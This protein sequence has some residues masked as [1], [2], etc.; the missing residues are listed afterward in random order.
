MEFQ[1][2]N[3]VGGVSDG[4]QNLGNGTGTV[5]PVPFSHKSNCIG[6]H[7]LR[8]SFKKKHLAHIAKFVSHIWGSFDQDGFGLWSYDSRLSW[9]S[10]VSLNYDEDE[11]RSGRVHAGLITLDCPGSALDEVTAPDLQLFIEFCE[12]FGGKCTRIDIFFDDYNRIVTPR[13]VFE[14]AQKGDYSGFRCWSRRERGDRKSCLHDEIAF[15]RRGSYGNGAYLRFYDKNLES[16][17]ESNCC[18]WEVEFTQKKADAVFKK[19]AACGGDID[20]FVT[21]CGSLIAGCVTFIHRTG[22]KNISR[23]ER[24]AWWSAILEIL[25]GVVRVRIERKKD[26]VTGKMQWIERNVAPS[27]ACLKRVFVSD[28]SFF[29]WLFDTLHDG[30]SRMNPFTQQIAR[31][32]ECSINYRWGEFSDHKEQI[33]DKSMSQL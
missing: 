31:E 17:G 24:Y 8:I 23:L 7:W 32:N 30:E 28:K 13:E 6:V 16:D 29:R 3:V 19:L 15:G 27:L 2:R 20:S 11:E 5:L 12:S 10:G 26:S 1:H 18:R 22:D 21:L 25:G 4:A 14:V 33:Y 9:V